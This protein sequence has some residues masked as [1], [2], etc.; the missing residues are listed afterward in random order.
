LDSAEEF[1]ALE[2][3]LAFV[4]TGSV[5][6]SAFAG[7]AARFAIETAA[8]AV[9]KRAFADAAIAGFVSGLAPVLTASG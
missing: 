1:V 5:F 6:E 4:D 2:C 8:A 9:S 3:G 7:F